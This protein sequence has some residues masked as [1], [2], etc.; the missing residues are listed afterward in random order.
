MVGSVGRCSTPAPRNTYVIPTVAAVL[1][2]SETPH[3]IRAALGGGVKLTSKTALLQADVE[4]HLVSTHAMVVDEIGAD[5]DGRPIEVLLAPWLCSSGEFVRFPTKRGSTSATTPRSSSSSNSSPLAAWRASFVPYVSRSAVSTSSRTNL[6]AGKWNG[7]HSVPPEEGRTEFIPFRPKN[8]FH[9]KNERNEFR[10]TT[11]VE[12]ILNGMPPGGMKRD[13]L[14]KERSTPR[15]RR[16]ERASHR[17]S[18]HSTMSCVDARIG[19]CAGPP[20]CGKQEPFS[21]TRSIDG[22]PVVSV[23]R[24]PW[25]FPC[26]AHRCVPSSRQR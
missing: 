1:T 18:V 5:E 16:G 7:I 23:S 19:Q 15:A 13:Q 22:L 20:E 26:T 2:T 25:F 3:P 8:P 4:G 21:P 10:S 14:V 9:P 11:V 17:N 6:A 12:Q 24:L